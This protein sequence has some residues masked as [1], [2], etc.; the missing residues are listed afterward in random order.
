M[1]PGF[2]PKVLGAI[3]AGEGL[4]CPCQAMQEGD[5]ETDGR[6]CQH[7]DEQVQTQRTWGSQRAQG[8]QGP[9]LFGEQGSLYVTGPGKLKDQMSSGWLFRY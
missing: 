2:S 7:Q 6:Q 4:A 5:S 3:G 1:A 8:A 9:Q